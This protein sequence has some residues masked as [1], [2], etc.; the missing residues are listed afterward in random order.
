ME[1]QSDCYTVKASKFLGAFLTSLSSSSQ[2]QDTIQYIRM[3][4][5]AVWACAIN[6]DSSVSRQPVK[7]SKINQRTWQFYA[8][9]HD[10][11][12]YRVV[13]VGRYGYGPS[14]GIQGPSH[15]RDKVL[16]SVP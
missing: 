15:T 12:L 4:Y 11:S 7:Y 10:C 16:Q 14:G 3:F 9:P 1:P 13:G 5:V 6:F 8:F 2:K